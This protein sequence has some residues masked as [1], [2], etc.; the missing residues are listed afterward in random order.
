MCIRDSINAEY[1]EGRAIAMP[2]CSNCGIPAPN[3]SRCTA[4]GAAVR[5]R[6]PSAA[7]EREPHSPHGRRSRPVSRGAELGIVPLAHRQRREWTTDRGMELAGLFDLMDGNQDQLLELSELIVVFGNFACEFLQECDGDNDG[8]G[9][10]G[11][12]DVR[13]VP[14]VRGIRDWGLK[15]DC[16]AQR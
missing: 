5:S 6:P 9:W 13:R 16:G 10:M 12:R 1:G 14:D 7:L 15:G 3:H 2:F 11:M 8:M 4:C